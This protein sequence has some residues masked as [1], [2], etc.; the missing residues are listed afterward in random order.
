MEGVREL[1]VELI[2]PNPNQPR[3]TIDPESL[4]ALADSL[5]EQGVL[6]PVLVRPLA[7]GYELIAGE[8]R[9]RAARLAG[10]ERIPALVRPAGDAQTLE[11]AL[12]E[13]MAREDLNPIEEARACAALAEELGLTRE[14]IGRRVGRSRVAI[15]NLVRLLELPDE[16]LEMLEQGELSEGHGRALL[17]A[18]DHD[19]RRKLARAAAREGWSVRTTER[20][21]REANA[22]AGGVAREARATGVHPDREAGAKEIAE[23]L[24]A[25][26]GAH[27][28]V[29]CDAHG[30]YTAELSFASYEEAI[31]LARRLRPRSVA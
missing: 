11:L 16:V 29:R 19:A 24:E 1:P 20:R 12:I 17:M 5:G 10:I 18:E 6:Q 25:A 9:W 7:G 2:A 21:A 13:N 27:V 3:R 22:V 4:Q 23:T 30:R 8:R 28:R 31:S 14:E 26:L 15:S